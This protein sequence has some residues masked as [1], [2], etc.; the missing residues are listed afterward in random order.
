MSLHTLCQQGLCDPS[1]CATFMLNPHWRR[2]ATAKK[3][4]AS[5][6]TGWLWSCPTLCDPVNCGL[7]GISVRGLLQ[8]RILEWAAISFSVQFSSVTQLCLTLCDPWK[9]APQAFLS[10]TNSQSLLKVMSIESVM[11][12][13]HLI[14]CHLF[15]SC[16]QSSP[17]PGSFQM[18]Q[19]FSS[20][21]QSIGVS[22]SVSILSMNI[23]D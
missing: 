21:G 14:L 1:S 22:A 3:S 2:A 8:A 20:G 19:F 5:M 13:N 18:S 10:I 7:P 16:F 15:S 12:S 9:A 17:A 23:Q 6:H 11:P 4:L